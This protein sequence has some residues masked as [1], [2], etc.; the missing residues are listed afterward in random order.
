MIQLIADE[1]LDF[2][3]IKSLRQKGFSVISILETY[4]GISDEEVLSIAVKNNAILITEDKDFGELVY[5]MKKIHFGVILVRL[6]GM[7][8]IQK[9]TICT[10]SIEKNIYEMQN[11]FSVISSQ[12]TRIKKLNFVN[13]N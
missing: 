10:E 8:S 5:R 6:I 1:N 13:G 7:S 2:S 9:M 4:S 11:S 12:Q 3:I